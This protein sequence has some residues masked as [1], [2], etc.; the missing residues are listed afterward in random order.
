MGILVNRSKGVGSG[1]RGSKTKPWVSEM[2]QQVKVLAANPGSLSLVLDIHKV[3]VRVY[4]CDLSSDLTA[5]DHGRIP[6]RSNP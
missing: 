1:R 2:A 3:E 6:H 5:V 4:S